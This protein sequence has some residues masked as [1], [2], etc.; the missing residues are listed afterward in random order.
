MELYYD[1]IHFADAGAAGQI[2]YS[3]LFRI[4]SGDM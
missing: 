3:L 1:N 2:S 4:T